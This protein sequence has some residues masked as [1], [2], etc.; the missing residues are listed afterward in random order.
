MAWNPSTKFAGGR[1]GSRSH[2]E[3]YHHGRRI[4]SRSLFCRKVSCRATCYTRTGIFAD[5]NIEGTTCAGAEGGSIDVEIL[6]CREGRRPKMYTLTRI[7][8]FFHRQNRRP[9]S[10]LERQRFESQRVDVNG[11]G[12]RELLELRGRL[13]CVVGDEEVY[14]WRRLRRLRWAI[15][16]TVG[17]D[18]PP[19]VSRPK[20]ALPPHGQASRI[21]PQ[22]SRHHRY[23]NPSMA[24]LNPQIPR[25]RRYSPQRFY[26]YPRLLVRRRRSPATVDILELPAQAT[27]S[28]NAEDLSLSHGSLGH[29]L[30]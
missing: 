6:R 30:F 27:L 3:R 19:T 11:D 7:Y 25:S 4:D 5:G 12:W 23:R 28:T 21:E 24:S 2:A 15:D 10:M 20:T 14:H 26:I 13:C 16:S 18:L 9:R 29:L 22:T 8:G 17:R 1:S